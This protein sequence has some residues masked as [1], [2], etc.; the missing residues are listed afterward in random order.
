MWQTPKSVDARE[1]QQFERETDESSER[2]K[3][4]VT[5]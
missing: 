3:K 5:G 4:I 2:T 1:Q